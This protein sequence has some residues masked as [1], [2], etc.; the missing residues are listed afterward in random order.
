M[1]VKVT[2]PED[3]GH[4]PLAG[5][6]AVFECTV[7]DLRESVETAIDD[8]FAT[9]MG[10]E[11]LGALK[12]AVRGQLGQEYERYARERVKRALLDK[13]ADT[14][15]FEIPPRMFEEE[16]EQIWK[17]VEHAKEHGHTDAEIGRASCRERVCPYVEV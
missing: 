10:M 8:A 9:A 14:H 13:L 4:E 11:N 2:F 3:Y 5:K 1:E 17:Q 7:S 16:F 15:D 6:D 12:D